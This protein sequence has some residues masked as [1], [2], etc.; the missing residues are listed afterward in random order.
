MH[1]HHHTTHFTNFILIINI[2]IKQ[3]FISTAIHLHWIGLRHLNRNTLCDKVIYKYIIL[4]I[5]MYLVSSDWNSPVLHRWWEVTI[6]M[7]TRM[8]VIF[9][10]ISN[11]FSKVI[12]IGH[13]GIVVRVRP[14]DES[15]AI[16]RSQSIGRRYICHVFGVTSYLWFWC[17][18]VSNSLQQWRPKLWYEV[19]FKV[20]RESMRSSVLKDYGFSTFMTRSTLVRQL[21]L[22]MYLN[23]NIRWHVCLLLLLYINYLLYFNI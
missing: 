18:S 7:D 11:N 19:E 17:G 22:V 12:I 4:Y 5:F 6:A 10:S 14:S 23:I 9:A 16:V 13:W 15:F 3:T 1:P 21:V 2:C 20:W 8:Y